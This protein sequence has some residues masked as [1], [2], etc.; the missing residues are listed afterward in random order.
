MMAAD[1]EAVQPPVKPDP[2][3]IATFTDMVLGYCE[4]F[5]PVRA[6]AEKGGGDHMPH[7]PF[8]E[9][10]AEL[11]GKLAV[12]AGWAADNG[13]ALF[14]VPGTV[15]A[16]GEAKAEH[17]AQTQVVLVDLDHGDIGAKRDHLA[18]HLGEPSLEVAS[19]GITPE[20]QRKLHLYWQV[21]YTQNPAR[22]G[23]LKSSTAGRGIMISAI[24]S[25]L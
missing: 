4:H 6:L 11:A 16:A 22:S 18:R 25:R 8:M 19:G 17:I 9:N 2:A 20:G 10:D 23:L 21:L 12:Q 5:V 13:M 24:W 3:M 14:V 7:T 1:N 15:L